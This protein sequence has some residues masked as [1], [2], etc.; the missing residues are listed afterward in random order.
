MSP[1]LSPV[2]P[3][4]VAVRTSIALLFLR[5]SITAI[6]EPASSVTNSKICTPV[7]SVITLAPLDQ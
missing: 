5:Q 4:A 6:L 7:L 2:C 3:V 1:A